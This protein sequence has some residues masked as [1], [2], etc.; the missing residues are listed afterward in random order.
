MSLTFQTAKD[1]SAFSKRHPKTPKE[2]EPTQ[3]EENKSPHSTRL[4]EQA[5]V[6]LEAPLVDEVVLAEGEDVGMTTPVEAAVTSSPKTSFAE[7]PT[8][9]VAV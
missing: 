2:M 9:T 5:I 3:S 7:P 1:A 8:L 4:A 6:N